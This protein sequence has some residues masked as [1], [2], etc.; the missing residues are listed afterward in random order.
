[1]RMEGEAA[2]SAPPCFQ[3]VGRGDLLFWE[4]KKG[5]MVR[6]WES[7]SEREKENWLEEAGMMHD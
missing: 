3:S 4:D 5:P 2:M 6:I 7:L 1:M